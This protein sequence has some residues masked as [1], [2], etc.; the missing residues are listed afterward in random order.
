MGFEMNGMNAR[1]R[2]LLAVTVC[3]VAVTACNTAAN[4]KRSPSSTT[5]RT[6][7]EGSRRRRCWI[8][9]S[10]ITRSAIRERRLISRNTVVPHCAFPM[11]FETVKG[12][13]E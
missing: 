6:R 8:S 5:P 12:P 7:Y 3:A 4:K 9:A 13:S 1:V 10:N 11:D 2:M